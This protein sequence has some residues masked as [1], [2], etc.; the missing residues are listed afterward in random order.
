MTQKVEWK[1]TVFPPFEMLEK[2]LKVWGRD[3]KVLKN[4]QIK[5][6]E[7]S[8]GMFEMKNAIC[9]FNCMS[10]SWQVQ[11]SE[12]E[13]IAIET[14]QNERGKKKKKTGG[15]GNPYLPPPA[16]PAPVNCELM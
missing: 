5:L 16:P 14:L 3:M 11:I 6:L 15:W 1:T 12:I 8:N 10:D 9:G 7:I 13:D 2:R 4:I